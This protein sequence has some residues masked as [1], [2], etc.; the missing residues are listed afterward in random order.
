MKLD[1]LKPT[2]LIRLFMYYLCSS[3]FVDSE[4]KMF[5]HIPIGYYNIWV[6]QC[7]VVVTIDNSWSIQINNKIIN[8]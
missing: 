5:I 1:S 6:K 7:P 8:L 2:L 4:K 3:E